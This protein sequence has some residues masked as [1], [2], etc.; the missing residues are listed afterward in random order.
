MKTKIIAHRGASAYRPENTIEAFS[1][2]LEQRADGIELDVHLTKDGR[3]VV[4]HDERLERVSNGTG[5]INNYTLSELKELSFNALLPDQPECRIPTLE[6]VFDLVK[7]SNAIVN[8]ELKTT[9]FAY[10]ELSEKLL[11]IE[12]EY[13]M[14]GRVI[15]SSFNH[16]SLLKLREL[17]HE[18]KIGLLYDLG[19]VDPWVYAKHVSANAIHPQCNSIAIMPEI[20][21]LCHENGLMVNVWV[22]NDR[23]MMEAMFRCGT[24]I[25]ITDYPDEAV[26]CRNSLAIKLGSS[27][28]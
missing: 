20:V 9:E 22:V 13:A 21:A 24:D 8:V 5:C 23:Q 27:Y 16:Y 2:A 17:D 25:V 12:R 14:K 3:V 7:H 15:Y 11:K 6:E 1:L 28:Q 26:A 19:M 4:A 10:P 18:A